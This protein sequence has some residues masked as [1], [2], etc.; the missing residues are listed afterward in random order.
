MN[1]IIEK[2]PSLKGPFQTM[3]VVAVVLA[4]VF[5]GSELS[6]E[7]LDFFALS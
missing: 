3:A 4:V 5:K 7:C 1:Q 6:L 2:A